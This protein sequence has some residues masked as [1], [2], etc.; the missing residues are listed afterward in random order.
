MTK[1][2][3]YIF[4]ISQPSGLRRTSL[5]PSKVL[6]A[7]WRGGRWGRG[8]GGWGYST[9]FRS[10]GLYSYR[11]SGIWNLE[12]ALGQTPR[13]AREGDRWEKEE[14]EEEDRRGKVY[15]VKVSD[16]N[17]VL[18]LSLSPPFPS[19]LLL[20]PSSQYLECFMSLSY[21]QAGNLSR[22]SVSSKI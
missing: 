8:Q 17:F 10:H 20:L 2:G 14:V 7:W 4:G 5:I 13:R 3:G 11:L 21:S 9:H 1:G 15:T 12:W 6:L 16:I 18:S 22:L 19:P